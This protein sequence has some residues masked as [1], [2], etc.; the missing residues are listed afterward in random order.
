MYQ[1]NLSYMLLQKYMQMLA[2][3]GLIEEQNGR[4]YKTTPL[5][6]KYLTDYGEFKESSSHARSKLES[7]ESM[8][9]ARGRMRRDANGA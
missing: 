2:K 1:A 6:I 3:Q 8:L 7:L 5:G 4:V 9:G